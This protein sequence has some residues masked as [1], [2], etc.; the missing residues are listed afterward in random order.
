MF[1][2]WHT[3]Y[4]RVHS[5]LPFLVK[6]NILLVRWT[7]SSS[8]AP[9]VS[10]VYSTAALRWRLQWKKIEKRHGIL[11][12]K[13]FIMCNYALHWQICMFLDNTITNKKI[14]FSLVVLIWCTVV[15]KVSETPLIHLYDLHPWFQKFGRFKWEISRIVDPTL[16]RL[17][18]NTRVKL[19][20]CWRISSWHKDNNFKF[21]PKI[22]T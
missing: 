22:S 6:W 7:V 14:N 20:Y 4:P 19:W 13:K 5:F 16:K 2:K 9:R 1:L 10:H 3:I 21:I 18:R 11:V 12:E 17:S 15:W 8:M